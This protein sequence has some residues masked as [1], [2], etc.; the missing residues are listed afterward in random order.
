MIETLQSTFSSYYL[1]IK[2]VHV[3]FVMMWSWSTAVAYGWYVKGAFL[4]WEINPDDPKSIARRNWAIEQF[5]KGVVLEHIAFPIILVTGPL[6]WIIGG[7]NHENPWFLLKILVVVFIFAPIEI[8]DYYLSHFGGNKYKL[9]MRGESV[10][11]ERA[12]RQ[13]WLFLR[14]TTPLIIVFMPMAIFL[15]IVKPP[16]W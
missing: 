9:R 11:Y 12:I 2:F 14:I 13:H 8:V 15:A 3:F 4:S 7:W 10:K 1:Y 5:D 16:L 6:L